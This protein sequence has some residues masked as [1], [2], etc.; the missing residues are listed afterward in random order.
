MANTV[1]I[2]CWRCQVCLGGKG[3]VKSG[4]SLL[5]LVCKSQ[6]SSLVCF[7]DDQVK[8]CQMRREHFIYMHIHLTLSNTVHEADAAGG[9]DH[10]F[11]HLLEVVRGHPC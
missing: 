4:N 3:D 11:R 8:K 6:T 2:Q 10:I 9:N 1:G 7:I 5:V